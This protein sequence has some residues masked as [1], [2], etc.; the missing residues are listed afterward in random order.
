ME[1]D[2]VFVTMGATSHSKSEREKH[3]YYATHPLAVEKLLE[4]EKFNNYIWECAYGE[5]HIGDILEKE[6]YRVFKTDIIERSRVLDRCI[7]F[8]KF[9]NK[10]ERKVDIVTNPPYK[11]AKEFVEKSLAVVKEG[12]KIA[13][14]LKLTFLESV[15]RRKLFDEN[16]PKCV[17]VFSKR[18]SC[19]RNG[20]FSIKNPPN[21]VAFAWFVWIKGY[22]GDTVVKWIN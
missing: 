6:G 10:V 16:P 12:C 21:A 8:L 7:D 1:N 20:D 11:Y 22:K 19:Y 17:Y 9:N 3:D 18:I 5:G 15:S 14:F 4:V 2:K 13:M